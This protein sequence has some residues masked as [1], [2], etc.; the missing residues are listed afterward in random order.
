MFVL[1]V[2]G[3]IVASLFLSN[4]KQSITKCGRRLNMQLFQGS[5]G[6]MQCCS[7]GGQSIT[8]KASDMKIM[9]LYEEIPMFYMFH[10][11]FFPHT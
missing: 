1:P 8:E 5:V 11:K 9:G 7:T 10:L 2:S 3:R 6:F 4:G